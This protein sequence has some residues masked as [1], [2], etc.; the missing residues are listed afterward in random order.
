MLGGSDMYYDYCPIYKAVPPPYMYYNYCHV[1]K[2]VPPP[3]N[4]LFTLHL[5]RGM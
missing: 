1:C 4:P 3:F 2:S 5:R